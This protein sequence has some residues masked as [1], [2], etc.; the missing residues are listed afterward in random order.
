[1]VG[2]RARVH[3]DRLRPRLIGT[4]ALGLVALLA[5]SGCVRGPNSDSPREIGGP[6]PTVSEVH[7]VAKGL[8]KDPVEAAERLVG[9]IFGTDRRASLAA[10]AEIFRRSGL[11]MIDDKPKVVL[12]PDKVLAGDELVP[13]VDIP[14]VT[15]SVL[16]GG[17][18]DPADFA[19]LLMHLGVT[20]GPLSDDGVAALVNEWGKL[21]ESDANGRFAGAAMRAMGE[22]RD[23]VAPDGAALRMDAVQQ[24]I[25]F[26]QLTATWVERPAD[27][28][29]R[30]RAGDAAEPELVSA[31]SSV[32]R[33]SGLAEECEKE[34]NKA[35]DLMHSIVDHGIKKVNENIASDTLETA[36]DIVEEDVTEKGIKAAE[37]LGAD[38]GRITARTVRTSKL[39]GILGKTVEYADIAVTALQTALE[40]M[41]LSKGLRVTITDD[42]PDHKTHFRHKGEALKYTTFTAKVGFD[43]KF[44]NDKILACYEALGIHVPDGETVAGENSKGE[45]TG[46]RV[47]WT[48]G[49]NIAPNNWYGSVP[50]GDV[51]RPAAP[52]WGD[53]R[54]PLGAD[55]TAKMV[56]R[57]R[58]ERDKPQN[59]GT[60]H[61]VGVDVYAKVEYEKP[62][63]PL[64]ILGTADMTIAVLGM[65]AND[66]WFPK[67]SHHLTVGYHGPDVYVAK[68][69][70]SLNAMFLATMDL[71][72]DAYSCDGLAGPWKASVENKGA[73][74]ALGNLLADTFGVTGVRNGKT[75]GS[76]SFSLNPTSTSPQHGDVAAGYGLQLTF[77]NV[78]ERGEHIDGYVGEGTWTLPGS[79]EG[80]N[81]LLQQASMGAF[82]SGLTFDVRGVPHDAHCPG[83]AF[84][85]NGWD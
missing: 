61:E 63:D 57:P 12:A 73:T 48:I 78:P 66:I 39:L 56:T 74:A 26:T 37:E 80:I 81:S 32:S 33:S 14:W 16:E 60:V 82:G 25:L 76:G 42:A 85:E 34:V 5:L 30:A 43:R 71:S 67:V 55:G 69:N 47:D 3:R 15:D 72:A 21:P 2:K 75:G 59:A 19:T 45:S 83:P 8:P 62:I 70:G 31:V 58:T 54:Q 84:D 38:S 1:M 4:V 50:H 20:D 18:V 44:V 79:K 28:M 46:W 29:S 36:A 9:M 77:D 22:Y 64:E 11:A 35:K 49:E 41:L 53:G 13:I 52:D 27:L 68:G 6:P 10:T 24:V 17:Y 65:V 40:S 51:I 7:A 23:D